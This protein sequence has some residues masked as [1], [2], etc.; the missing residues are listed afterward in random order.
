NYPGGPLSDQAGLKRG[1]A[2]E[3][4]GDLTDAARAYLDTFSAAPQGPL[5]PDALFRLGRALGRLGQ[6][7][8]ACLT[9]AEVEVR[10]PGGPAVAEAQGEM[11][12]LGCQ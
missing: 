10:F 2:L 5:A 4:A 11:Q 8:E 12:S 1:E 7:E 9:L 6:T 3:G